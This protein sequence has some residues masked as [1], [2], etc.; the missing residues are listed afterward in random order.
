ME[1]LTAPSKTN[2]VAEYLKVEIRS[3]KLKPGDKLLSTRKLANHFSTSKEVIESAYTIL[4]KEGL[5]FKRARKGVFVNKESKLSHL[6][7]VYI[8]GYGIQQG[9]QYFEQVLKLISPPYLRE[10]Y[11]FI[12]K[13]VPFAQISPECFNAEINNIKN[14]HGIDAVLINAATL[15]KQQIKISETIPSPVIFLGGFQKGKFTDLKIT[16]VSVKTT[17]AEK[18]FEYF[19]SRGHKKIALLISSM[20]Y[21]Y[22][23]EVV[24]DLTKEAEALGLEIFIQELPS[25]IHS[26]KQESR[27]SIIQNKL[28]KIK[29]DNIHALILS[30]ILF[31]IIQPNLDALKI[32][33]SNDIDM[34]TTEGFVDAIP[35]IEIDFSNFYNH[36]YWLLD[37][38]K[39]DKNIT[40][41]YHINC[42][43]NIITRNKFIL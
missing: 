12:I 5:V 37:E 27:D 14:T 22:N 9:S 16:Q 42:E 18:C 36:L 31:R 1:L 2:Q 28:K 3:Q 19:I 17:F 26:M 32:K 10:D 38:L 7:K 40:K 4:E 41:R 33:T 21:A 11:S 30:G 29:N 43:Y 8:L 13:N 25:G 23:I 6:T 15:S 34:L 39:Q 35:F 24:A 20:K